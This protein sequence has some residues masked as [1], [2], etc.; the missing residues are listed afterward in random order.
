[1]PLNEYGGNS[2]PGVVV[3]DSVSVPASKLWRGRQ[4]QVPGVGKEHSSLAAH[5][6]SQTGLQAA[7]QPVSNAQYCL[8]PHVL[9]QSGASAISQPAT[10]FVQCGAV[11]AASGMKPAMTVDVA[12][13]PLVA[14]A[15][16]TV[17]V[18][19]ACGPSGGP[20]EPEPPQAATRT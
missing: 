13:P 16:V 2:V 17:I 1:M 3:P 4:P 11:V 15:S 18:P 10:V 8:A 12:L 14:W 9:P 6:E 7:V 20:P 5:I 19:I